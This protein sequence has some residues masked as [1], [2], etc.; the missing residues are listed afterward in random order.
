LKQVEDD[1]RV[2]GI[3]T[4]RLDP[5]PTPSVKLSRATIRA[6]IARLADEVMS[7]VEF[8]RR[9]LAWLKSLDGTLAAQREHRLHG[10]T[11]I[12]F[13]GAAYRL[14]RRNNFIHELYEF[15]EQRVTWAADQ[16]L[17]IA[18]YARKHLLVPVDSVGAFRIDARRLDEGAT[19]LRT[20]MLAERDRLGVMLW[21]LSIDID[22]PALGQLGTDTLP[23][24]ISLRNPNNEAAL[25]K[26]I[27]T[28]LEEAE[29]ERATIL[30]FPELSIPPGT[31]AFVQDVLNR[32]GRFGHPLLTVLG[33]CHE[34]VGTADVNECVLLGPD[35]KELSRHRKLAPFAVGGDY[36]CGERLVTGDTI[37]VIESEAGNLTMLIC[38]D[39]FHQQTVEALRKSNANVL[40]VPSLSQ[41]TS[42]HQT[43]ARNLAASQLASTFVTNRRLYGG[44]PSQTS[45]AGTSFYRLPR[46][47]DAL[48][49]HFPD[50]GG[51][52]TTYLLFR[53]PPVSP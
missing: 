1:L 30:I 25:K 8:D 36:P 46:S 13:D 31:L 17:S 16:G 51:T 7:G 29:K 45:P 10:S 41:T 44:Q 33:L 20:R 38:L 49:C 42:A 4:L 19:Y 35:G 47:D 24:F 21:P 37:T 27:G 43:G 22:F 9:G 18:N 2:A 3:Q 12:G 40:F 53:V 14:K 34:S 23:P 50:A 11:P 15:V 32:R 26:E 28:A 52:P 5:D 48:V 6:C 39:L